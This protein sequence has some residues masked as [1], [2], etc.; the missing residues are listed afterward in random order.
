MK[1]YTLTA[2]AAAVGLAFCATAMA[3]TM[4]K[5][6]YKAA[7]KSIEADYK[8][9]KMGCEPLQANAKD[10]CVAE[11]KGKEKVA[12][13]ELEATYKHTAKTRYQARIAKAEADYDVAKEKCDDKAGNEKDV[14]MKEAKAA[15]IAAKADVKAHKQVAEARKDAT[16]EKRD[17]D[18]AVAKEKCEA[19]KGN[20]K[21]ACVGEAKRLYGKS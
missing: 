8:S 13:A 21:D 6:E 19:F 14:C 12:F 20:E 15:L 5:D 16:L 7:K 17:A 10:I 9:A 1:T 11:A 4:P 18:Y 3:N 2:I